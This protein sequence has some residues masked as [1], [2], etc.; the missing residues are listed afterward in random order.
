MLSASVS[1]TLTWAAPP[2][3]RCQRLAPRPR[4][5]WGSFLGQVR[6]RW[7]TLPFRLCV[8]P[9]RQGLSKHENQDLGA[10]R[11]VSG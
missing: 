6:D 3:L 11:E 9:G 4:L 8:F 10:R 5:P 1:P 7:P 2:W